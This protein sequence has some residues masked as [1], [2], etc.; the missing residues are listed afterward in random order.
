[1]NIQNLMAQAQRVQKDLE[2]A[3]HE[4][5]E[6]TNILFDLINETLNIILPGTKQK[7]ECKNDIIFGSNSVYETFEELLNGGNSL[8]SIPHLLLFG[9][10][11][12]FTELDNNNEF[13]TITE[14][15]EKKF[16][17]KNKLFEKKFKPKNKLFEEKFKPKNKLFEKKFKQK[18][19]NISGNI[20]L[21]HKKKTKKR[22]FKNKIIN[23]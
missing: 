3:L 20:Y 13:K 9:N 11:D 1:M 18:I 7:N 16:K 19:G 22:N 21:I 17:P 6:D 12:R 4:A 15:F 14:L 23:L 10:K 8:F 2:R 5:N